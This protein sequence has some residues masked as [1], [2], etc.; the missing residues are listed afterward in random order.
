MINH[1]FL[2][3][4]KVSLQDIKMTELIFRKDTGV[5]QGKGT[6]CATPLKTDDII[7]PPE[8]SYAHEYTTLIADIMF[9][10]N[11]VFRYSVQGYYILHLS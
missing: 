3:K 5:L 8:N 1:N 6:W 4:A 9:S 11:S 7:V 10:I 2:S